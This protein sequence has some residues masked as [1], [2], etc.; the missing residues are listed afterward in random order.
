MPSGRRVQDA[1]PHDRRCELSSSYF[2][3]I[4][5]LF[6]NVPLQ[7]FGALAVSPVAVDALAGEKF[8]AIAVLYSEVVP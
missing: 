6:D 4:P 5:F 2:G 7:P 1:A 3:E 8:R